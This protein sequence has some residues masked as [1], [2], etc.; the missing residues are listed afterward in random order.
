MVVVSSFLVHIASLS[1]N[2]FRTFNKTC[3]MHNEVYVPVYRMIQ[4][5]SSCSSQGQMNE[6]IQCI[7]K[8]LILPPPPQNEYNNKKFFKLL[9]KEKL[10]VNSFLGGLVNSEEILFL[11]KLSLTFFLG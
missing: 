6:M 10:T 7:K 3:I 8:N 9:F 4:V 11:L 1:M 2:G 5:C